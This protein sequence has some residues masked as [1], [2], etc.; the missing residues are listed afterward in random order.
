M[1]TQRTCRCRISL[2]AISSF[3]RKAVLSLN[4]KL[5]SWYRVPRPTPTFSA[6][7]TSP[8]LAPNPFCKWLRLWFC[9]ITKPWPPGVWCVK[10]TC[11]VAREMC[12]A[13]TL[14][15]AECIV[16]LVPARLDLEIAYIDVSWGKRQKKGGKREGRQNTKGREW[17]SSIVHEILWYQQQHQQ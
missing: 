8:K 5:C 15:S 11:H 3:C 6:V 10:R 16:L 4:K 12:H 7:T 13:S 14:L 2:W 1:W 9:G 17:E